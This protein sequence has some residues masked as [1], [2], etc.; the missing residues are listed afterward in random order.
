MDSSYQFSEWPF[1]TI[2]TRERAISLWADRR[3]AAEQ[4][5][6]VFDFWTGTA[7]S[8]INLLWA[9]LG[10]GKTHTLFHIEAK[11][12]E[13]GSL[14]PLYVLLPATIT[15][16][17]GLYTAIAKEVDWRVVALEFNSAARGRG[18]RSLRRVLDWYVSEGDMKRRNLAERWLYG[19]RLSQAQ[20]DSLGV[21]TS[22]G[23]TEDAV[24]IL[25]LTI[26]ALSG[27]VRRVV[28][29]I[30]EYQRVAEGNRRQ[31]QDIGHAMH[32]LYNACPARFSLLLSCAMG[33]HEDYSLV[34]T[35]E[36]VSRLSMLRIEL[37]YLT[38]LDIKDYVQDLFLHYRRPGASVDGFYPLSEDVV[39]ALAEFLRDELDDQ[40]TPRRLN[41]ACSGML[42]ELSR[43]SPSLPISVRDF[44][45]WRERGAR[46]ILRKLRE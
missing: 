31:L 6:A 14:V 44:T 8:T 16:F 2:P 17:A 35:P 13:A 3:H 24:E 30:D 28:L 37:P 9:D 18:A 29:M 34:L 40:V 21:G 20:C 10:A 42:A 27:G 46:E 43:W 33:S 7:V 32:T 19:E 41:E 25:H 23:S 38:S 5:R 39:V 26:G 11:C 15:K 45:E 22:I 36:L 4:V 12:R 1:S